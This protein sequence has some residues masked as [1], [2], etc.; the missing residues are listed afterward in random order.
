MAKRVNTRFL[1]WVT[2]AVVLVLGVLLFG[3]RV[4]ARFFA[5]A[6]VAAQEAGIAQGMVKKGLLDEARYHINLAY[7]IDHTDKQICIQRG[8]I[9]ASLT[10]QDGYQSMD[11]ARACRQAALDID[12]KFQPALQRLLDSYIDMIDIAPNAQTFA[13]LHDAAAEVVKLDPGNERARAYE[14]I[15]TIQQWVIG[16]VKSAS[17]IQKSIDTLAAIRKKDP[18]L[19]EPLFYV[20]QGRRKQAAQYARGGD[21]DKAQHLLALCRADLSESTA[22]A[23]KSSLLNLRAFDCYTM[24][25]GLES[26]PQVAKTDLA[27]AGKAIEL[28]RANALPS[29]PRYTDV[30]FEAVE[31]AKHKGHPEEAQKFLRALYVTRNDQRARLGL[32]RLMRE[33]GDPAQR[34]AAIKLLEAPVVATGERVARIM[35]VRLLDIG[36]MVELAYCR[37]DAAN[38]ATDA[39]ARKA[40]IAQIDEGYK[41]LGAI[42]RTD[43]PQVLRLAGTIAQLEGNPVEA[44]RCL[45]KAMTL[46]EHTGR[47]GLDYYET[48]YSLARANLFAGQNRAAEKLLVTVTNRFDKFVPAHLLLAQ[49]FL[50]ERD[51]R[52][53]APQVAA[54]VRLDPGNPEVI[55]LQLSLNQLG[56]QPAETV[57]SKQLYAK[58]PE[59]T[60]A[61]K[62]K[63][64]QA[65][66]MLEDMPETLR[67]LGAMRQQTQQHS[68]ITSALVQSYNK[69]G[70][71]D[72][73]QKT[74]TAA[75]KLTPD[76]AR[77]RVLQKQLEHASP[78]EMNQLRETLSAANGD[79][80]ARE[81]QQGLMALGEG[82]YD[83]TMTHARKA[84]AM[85]PN[86]PT[87]WELYFNVYTAQRKWDLAQQ[88]VDNLAR[89]N[90]DKAGGRMY[91]WM[92]AM[93]RGDLA[94]AI[95]VGRQLTQTNENF[96]RSWM[97]LAQ[98]YQAN[99]QYHDAID[100][101]RAAL[102]R[103]NTDI[104]VYRGLAYC[105]E[106]IGQPRTAR[107]TIEAGR[108]I[109]PDDVQ[110]REVALAYDVNVNPAAVVPIREKLLKDNPGEPEN[111]IRLASACVHAA[112]R[113]YALDPIAAKKY[114]DQAQSVL[115]KAVA[116]F[117]DN[118]R[119]N[120]AL[121]ESLQDGGQFEQGKQVLDQV[122]SD[123]KMQDKTAA[124]LLLA[125][126][127]ARAK[128]SEPAE[129]A[130]REAWAQTKNKDLDI[131]QR[132]A[133]YL[134]G[135]KKFD[136][137]IEVL[138]TNADEPR[139]VRLV[140][141]T[142]IAA[143]HTVLAEK[144]LNEALAK[145]PS[146]P[147]LMDLLIGVYI[148]GARYGEAR[149]QTAKV[150]KLDA[151]NDVALYYQALIELRDPSG[152]DMG[153]ARNDLST[154]V[155]RNPVNL[156]YKQAYA[157]ALQRAH[158]VDAAAVQLEEV[159]KIDPLSR[160]AR[161]RLLEI[162]S[163]SG[164][165]LR[166]N[167]AVQYAQLNDKLNADPI[168]YKVHANALASQGFYGPA[169]EKIKMAINLAKSERE[170]AELVRDY[171]GILLQARDY[172]AMMRETDKLLEGGHHDWWVYQA[173]AVGMAVAGKR[174]QS[175]EQFGKALA[176]AD[177]AKDQ[178]GYQSAILAMANA[179]S[180]D[181]ARARLADKLATSNR[182]KLL[183]VN[184]RMRKAD[185]VGALAELQ[186][187]MADPSVARADRLAAYRFA[188]EAYQY[189]GQNDKARDCYIQWL[190]E[191]PNDVS[192]LNNFALLLAENM[193]KPQEA[194]VYSQRAYD[195]GRKVGYVDSMVADTHGWVLTLCKGT[196]ASD[197][198]NILSQ[199]VQD[200]PNF[201]EARYHLAMALIYRNQQADAIRQLTAALAQIKTLEDQKAPVRPELK[202]TVEDALARARLTSAAR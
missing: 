105:Y 114:T 109:F 191:S 70:R 97:L 33:T 65:A 1:L 51:S 88:A 40:I 42:A 3:P 176:A 53:A 138:K 123:P 45:S 102:D 55:R 192:V 2:A 190:K 115:T 104:A 153:I 30:Q 43:D 23:P 161:A 173:R 7:Q 183:D 96:G 126:Y 195:L 93:S 31:W 118:L 62:L 68:V 4:K 150:L 71:T 136:A 188:A 56:N 141:E 130:I 167:E 180:V 151:A 76:D 59:D 94:D 103:Q 61:A 162:Y 113:V 152:G 34:E 158:D 47:T 185:I 147:E 12:P 78:Q 108:R 117:P 145:N 137:A 16:G 63:K 121:A 25:A 157:E 20:I 163:S 186:P 41:K 91:R 110:L 81:V 194:R 6:G 44:V 50:Q 179:V 99:G 146:N 142:Q 64:V 199:L 165:W 19:S 8:D 140:L 139:V 98:A 48:M 193:K 92:L 201:I 106:R 35:G 80:F 107:E 178:D 169:I 125:D 101:F 10:E 143:K 87:V 58:L 120:G 196:D 111:Y 175:L 122:I 13:R 29:D 132:L 160:E 57:D 124:L 131:E 11:T 52:N 26:D 18:T 127:Y 134:V 144:G 177:E 200:H 89:L 72:E 38:A 189:G 164:N 90:A 135:Q 28:A 95:A 85:R 170:G 182:W 171:L 154:V 5:H 82:K 32:A 69:T 84:D 14:Q 119:L 86:D 75:L 49:L 202:K 149:A 129:K 77:L 83:E 22:A 9:Y 112:Q 66:A 39:A 116:Q 100:N 184:L 74:L 36:R 15:A 133:A 159:L 17:E 46:M 181:E 155:N 168:W 198:M 187:L 67:L 148:D 54:L 197:G 24:I 156:T 27:A 60:F 37:I 128:M 166:F 174:E 21:P 73:A 172:A 79:P